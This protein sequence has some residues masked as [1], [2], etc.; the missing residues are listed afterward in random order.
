MTKEYCYILILVSLYSDTQ[1][2]LLLKL[3]NCQQVR[4][5]KFS[6]CNRTDS[7]CPAAVLV[8][9][10]ACAQDL[11]ST[12]YQSTIHLPFLAWDL[13]SICE[14]WAHKDNTEVKFGRYMQCLD[15]FIQLITKIGK[16]KVQSL[17]TL[18]VSSGT[19]TVLAK[20]DLSLVQL[21]H[22]FGLF[23]AT[24]C[25]FAFFSCVFSSERIQHKPI[26]CIMPN[27]I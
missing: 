6:A 3:I 1:V 27:D 19:N 10:R 13:Q 22:I 5:M 4:S 20:G 17:G 23:L 8:V 26:A 12:L 9:I 21:A 11:R 25:I 24:N 2:L 16:Q 18:G 15:K 14:S 7:V